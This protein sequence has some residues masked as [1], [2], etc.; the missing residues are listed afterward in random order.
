M[1]ITR[2]YNVTSYIDKVREEHAQIEKIQKEKAQI[3]SKLAE[4]LGDTTKQFS[5]LIEEIQ[6][7]G[8]E[9]KHN[10]TEFTTTRGPILF[11]D[12]K[13]DLLCYLDIKDDEGKLIDLNNLKK[14]VSISYYE[15][16]EQG[17]FEEAN[18]SIQNVKNNMV[19]ILSNE[20]KQLNKLKSISSKY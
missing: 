13:N 2:T 9:F 18:V 16:V 12:R 20:I 5:L 6:K 8:Y 1:S 19:G 4:V 3:I 14:I 15:I 17:Y 11:V 10:E 7:L